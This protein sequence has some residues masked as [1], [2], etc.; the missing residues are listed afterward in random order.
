MRITSFLLSLAALTL[1]VAAQP[2]AAQQAET[3]P[4][5]ASDDI[6]R[7]SIR[8][9]IGAVSR[10]S[11]AL[12]A[13]LTVEGDAPETHS[14]Q[15]S[16][17]GVSR[18]QR[19]ICTFPPLRIEFPSRQEAGLFQGQR[20]IKLVTHCR[21]QASHQQYVLLEYA[22]YRLYNAITPRSFGVRLAQIDYYRGDAQ[23]PSVSRVGFFIEDVD[24][25]AERNGMV[26][27]ERGDFPPSWLN[28][29]DTA[30]VALFQYMV[31]NLDWAVQAGPPGEDC[32]HN[33]KPIGPS[34][35]ATSN[36]VPLP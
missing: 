16:A 35:T 26:E 27:V 33:T 8:G 22:A 14:I 10:S 15:L 7:L 23:T 25:V 24:D 30:R 4:L 3:T 11:E 29:R 20:R 28:A 36:L 34:E 9:D 1:G 2:V 17:R 31:G 6:V 21:R 32:C 19:D 12:P 5:F 13:T 18:R